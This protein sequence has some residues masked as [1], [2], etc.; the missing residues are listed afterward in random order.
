MAT[1]EILS[2]STLFKEKIQLNL[3]VTFNDKFHG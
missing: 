3:W 2:L 1:V